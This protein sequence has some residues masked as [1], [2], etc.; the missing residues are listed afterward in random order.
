VIRSPNQVGKS[1]SGTFYL[2]GRI[3]RLIRE[4]LELGE[5]DDIVFGQTDSKRKNG[6][7]GLLTDNVITR[8]TLY[9]HAVIL[10]LLPFKNK[11]IYE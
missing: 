4:G 7:I 10:A 1:K 3:A 5:A 6:A 11:P 8:K 2:P 9:E